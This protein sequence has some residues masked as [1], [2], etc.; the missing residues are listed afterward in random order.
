MIPWTFDV[1]EA[2]K[3]FQRKVVKITQSCCSRKIFAAHHRSL[4]SISMV[5][6][7]VRSPMPVSVDTHTAKKSDVPYY[8]FNSA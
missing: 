6:A 1:F 5:A 7:V 3:R 2:V 4:N 8:N